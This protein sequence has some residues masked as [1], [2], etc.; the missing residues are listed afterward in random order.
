MTNVRY[1]EYC[2]EKTDLQRSHSI[3]K[4]YLKPAFSDSGKAISI[5]TSGSPNKYQIENS[6][7]RILCSDCEK[8]FNLKYDGP[9]DFL[10]NDVEKKR[11][12]KGSQI[13]T[14]SINGVTLKG[15]ITSVIWRA[16]ISN[17]EFYKFFQLK[18]EIKEALRYSLIDNYFT[19]IASYSIEYI[20]DKDK[21]Y[22][23]S[24]LNTVIIPPT[25]L[26][27]RKGLTFFFVARG[28]VFAMSIPKMNRAKEIKHG[29]IPNQKTIKI[30]SRNIHD[31]PKFIDLGKHAISNEKSGNSRV[32]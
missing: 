27:T 7:D 11:S 20:Y 23:H 22:E 29:L 12:K 9:A 8:Y 2:K 28:M 32:K 18:G 5:S 3:P 19:K 16:S 15:F 21:H 13:S 31:I 1:C 30:K 17:N 14:Q 6:H 26:E 4:S 10:A 24:S 25:R